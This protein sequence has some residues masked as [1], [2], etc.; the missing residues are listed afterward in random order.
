MDES[1]I[2]AWMQARWHQEQ[3]LSASAPKDFVPNQ[4]KYGQMPLILRVPILNLCGAFT[5]SMVM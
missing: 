2:A 3:F 1:L 5:F 4:E